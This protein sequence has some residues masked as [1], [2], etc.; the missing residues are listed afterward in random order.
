MIGFSASKVDG[1]A[2]VRVPLRLNVFDVELV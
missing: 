1:F 2:V